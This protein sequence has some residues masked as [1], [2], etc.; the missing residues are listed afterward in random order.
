MGIG[1]CPRR[2][3]GLSR[4]GVERNLAHLHDL[5][6][7]AVAR[8]RG[9]SLEAV[10][11]DGRLFIGIEAQDQRLIDKVATLDEVITEETMEPEDTNSTPIAGVALASEPLT[12][13][14]PKAEH[15]ARALVEAY[16]EDSN[17]L[18]VAR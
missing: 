8:G 10:P 6:T 13:E 18:P 7:Q 9:V 1:V 12:L 5:F 11:D 2:P 3:C 14:R 17:S 15:P 16:R 4:V